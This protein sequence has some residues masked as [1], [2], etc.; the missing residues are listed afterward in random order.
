MKRSLY[1]QSIVVV[2]ALFSTTTFAQFSDSTA[3]DETE[4]DD[5]SAGQSSELEQEGGGCKLLT[6]KRKS[7]ET[8]SLDESTQLLN[9]F[10]SPLEFGDDWEG[11]MANQPSP[12][13]FGDPNNFAP[14]LTLDE[15]NV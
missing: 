11:F 1:L 15:L 6:L 12:D 10:E 5:A 2:F 9:C 14:W 3:E 8:L 4:Q 7:G 13:A